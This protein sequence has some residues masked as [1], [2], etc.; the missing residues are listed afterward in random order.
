MVQ[1]EKL[2]QQLQAAQKDL[3]ATRNAE[4][5]ARSKAATEAKL[6]ATQKAETD[7][8][9]ANLRSEHAAELARL[10][11]ARKKLEVSTELWL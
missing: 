7:A 6:R 4:A 9:T 5:S 3:E 11:A 2:S 1:L 8:A 10:A